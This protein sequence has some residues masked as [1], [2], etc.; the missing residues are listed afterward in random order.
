MVAKQSSRLTLNPTLCRRKVSKQS[1]DAKSAHS[2]MRGRSKLGEVVTSKSL[3]YM[4]VSALIQGI[5]ASLLQ[6]DMAN[7]ELVHPLKPE[8]FDIFTKVSRHTQLRNHMTRLT[9]PYPTA[10]P[11]TP[12][13]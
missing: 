3:S 1:A 9:W 12:P 5:R 10:P 7:K 4:F 11:P 6:T 13:A 2:Q 8:D